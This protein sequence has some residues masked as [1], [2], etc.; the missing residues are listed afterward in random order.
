MARKSSSEMMLQVV[1]MVLPKTPG[2]VRPPNEGTL[3]RKA[4]PCQKRTI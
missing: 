1:S 4:L 2:V 3:R